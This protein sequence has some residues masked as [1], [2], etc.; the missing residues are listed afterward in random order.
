MRFP[1]MRPGRGAGRCKSNQEKVIPIATQTEAQ[2]KAAA[3]KA[4]ATRRRN[5][6]RRSR[7][8]QKAAETRARAQASTLK[9]VGWQAQRVADTALG[10]AVTA[11][12]KVAA[13]VEPLQ[14]R[15]G[16]NGEISRL[17]R[18]AATNLR[19][20]E[21]RGATARRNV[22]RTLGRQR[23][24]ELR[25]LSLNGRQAQQQARSTQDGLER[26]VDR[27]QTAAEELARRVKSDPRNIA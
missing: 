27:A 18:R 11:G 21:R 7:S 15:A 23:D 2:R 22:V 8:A 17:R 19:K 3:Q 25:R 20:A 6:A 13:T 1:G 26:Q 16:I 10:A 14:S 9:S 4:A 24:Q 12:E 5:A